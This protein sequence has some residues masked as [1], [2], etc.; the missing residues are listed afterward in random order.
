LPAIEFPAKF[1]TPVV[2]VAIYVVFEAMLP[3][4]ANVAILLAESKV[5]VPDKLGE[6]VKVVVLIVDASI[7]SLNVAVIIVVIGTLVPLG[8][9]VETTEG[10]VVSVT[11][12]DVVSVLEDE[13][14]LPP[15]EVK[16]TNIKK[17]SDNTVKFSIQVFMTFLLPAMALNGLQPAVM[18][19]T[20]NHGD[21]EKIESL[22]N[23]RVSV[24]CGASRPAHNK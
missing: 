10:D 19:Q 6:R 20:F 14:P 17:V 4:G 23:D 15:H 22:L 12:D 8:G 9:K 11:E 16:G 3:D 21:T 2:I 1:F 13:P 7:A 18:S 5:R 24:M